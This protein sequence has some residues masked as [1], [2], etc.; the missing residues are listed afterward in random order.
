[1][2]F[3]WRKKKR[4]I[5]TVSNQP[6]RRFTWKRHN[7]LRRFTNVIE[8]MTFT[9]RHWP[10][11]YATSDQTWQVWHGKI[12]TK[13]KRRSPNSAWSITVVY[14][15]RAHQFRPFYSW[16][17][18]FFG[19]FV[20]WASAFYQ[21][22][23]L[24]GISLLTAFFHLSRFWAFIFFVRFGFWAIGLFI[25]VLIFGPIFFAGYN[26]MGHNSQNPQQISSHLMSHFP[27]FIF[28][29]LDRN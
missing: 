22:V 21:F 15:G 9:E 5:P 19:P 3:L 6:M 13:W 20:F 18:G 23:G 29:R 28:K 10:S 4:R 1:M 24:L 12:V 14:L 11:E 17:L 25:A 27:G 16:A 2:T 7:R 26:Q 8:T